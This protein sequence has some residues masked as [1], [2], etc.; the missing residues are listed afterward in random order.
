MLADAV[1]PRPPGWYAL[2]VVALP[3][4]PIVLLF[5]LAA[6]WSR[7]TSPDPAAIAAWLQTRNLVPGDH[8]DV[9]LPLVHRMSAARGKIDVVVAPDGRIT[10]L[11]KTSIGWKENY[12]VFVYSTQEFEA[13]DV[14]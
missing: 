10:F 8:D 12:E 6:S 9:E 14:D 5:V 7:L 3:L 1:K 4:A 13:E 2:A 11:L